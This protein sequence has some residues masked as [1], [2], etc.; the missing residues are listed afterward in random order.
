MGAGDDAALHC[1]TQPLALGGRRRQQVAT[2]RNAVG[3]VAEVADGVA[4][5]TEDGAVFGGVLDQQATARGGGF[6]AA[7][8]VAIAVCPTHQDQADRGVPGQPDQ[9]C[10]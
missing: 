7:H 4:I 6:E 1:L 9:L 10:G 5:G 8:H 3:G 2:D